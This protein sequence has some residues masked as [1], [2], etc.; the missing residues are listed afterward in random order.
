MRQ[1]AQRGLIGLALGFVIGYGI[2]YPMM[3]L[4]NRVS[5]L[6]HKASTEITIL[7]G[8][9]LGVLMALSM[10]INMMHPPFAD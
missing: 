9:P 10:G 8:V 3:W 6:F 7:D 4:F 1:R 5:S 2:S